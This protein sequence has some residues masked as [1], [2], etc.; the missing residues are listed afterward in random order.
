MSFACSIALI[1]WILPGCPGAASEAFPGYVE[2]EY[3]ALAPVATARI[4][5]LRVRR[6]DT[7]VPGMI[8][9]T[10][11]NED[12]QTRVNAAEAAVAEASAML[13]N[14]SKGRRDV[15]IRAIEASL[16]AARAELKSAQLTLE[17]QTS[18]LRRGVSTEAS[19][20]QARAAEAVA[21]G[22]VQ[23]LEAN[24]AA[25]RLP[26][27]EDELHAAES[28]LAQARST[29][30][31]ARWQHQQRVLIAQTNGRISD[32]VRRPG[33]IAGPSQ[34]VVTFLPDGAVLVRFY[35]PQAFLA[36]MPVG[37]KVRVF[38]DGCPEDLTATISYRAPEPE[39]TPPV[40]YSI[41]RRQKLVY[42]IEARPDVGAAA[43][44][45]GQI[46]TVSLPPTS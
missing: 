44:E 1:A 2:G 5:Q 30:A 7:V 40:I 10:L 22:R 46:V 32:V 15:E 12:T 20:D 21:Q 27:R 8:L 45:P 33:E 17:R 19:T 42:L 36:R 38:C 39:F 14:L 29:L 24:L 16:V 31:E 35:S 43:L 6:G 23:E 34:P 4:K 11:D 26:A 28:R 25:A 9:A 13:A 37:A 18:L 3:A 41:E